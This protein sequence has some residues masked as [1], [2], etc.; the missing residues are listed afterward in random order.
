METR[1]ADRPA[2][3][4]WSSR[5]LVVSLVSLGLFLIDLWGV[6]SGRLAGPDRT[7]GLAIHQ[8]FGAGTYPAFTVV[9][10]LGDGTDRWILV[11]LLEAG[12]ALKRHWRPMLMLTVGVGGAVA[13]ESILNWVIARPRPHLFPPAVHVSGYSFPSGHTTGTWA[14]CFMAAYLCGRM[15]PPGAMRWAVTAAVLAFAVLVG[16]SRVVLGVHYASDVVGGVVYAVAWDAATI[17]L[18]GTNLRLTRSKRRGIE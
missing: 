18:L 17:W 6:L 8:A 7:V 14:L 11:A 1:C 15:L 9:T 16:L 3:G 12:F 13:T 4:S 5:W 10:N 2:H